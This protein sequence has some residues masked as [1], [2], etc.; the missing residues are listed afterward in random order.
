MCLILAGALL[1]SCASFK[2]T[3]TSG[4]PLDLSKLNEVQ[5]GVTDLRAILEWFGPPEQIIDGTREILDEQAR[6]TFNVPIATRTLSAPD[7]AVILLYP[8]QRQADASM[9]VAA[10]PFGAVSK[11]RYALRSNEMM[12]FIRKRDHKVLNV[13]VGGMADERP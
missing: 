6:M 3:T 5:V 4:T 12:I 13:L 2:S 10:S 11:D 1:G 9:V 8:N 7:G